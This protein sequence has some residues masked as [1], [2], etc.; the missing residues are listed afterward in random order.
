M[1]YLPIID[2]LT[3]NIFVNS[4]EN[5]FKHCE[6]YRHYAE[7]LQTQLPIVSHHESLTVNPAALLIPG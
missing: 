3:M 1:Y 2:G 5:S 4:L 6:H 7:S